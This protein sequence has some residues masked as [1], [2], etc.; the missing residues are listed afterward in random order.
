VDE[1]VAPDPGVWDKILKERQAAAAAEALAKAE[2][3]GRGR[4]AKAVCS[5]VLSIRTNINITQTVDYATEEKGADAASVA[6]DD[7][8]ED[9]ALPPSPIKKLSR[10]RKNKTGSESDT[11]FQADS[12]DESEPEPALDDVDAS[13][14]LGDTRHR[15]TTNIANSSL[16]KQN[17]AG[18]SNVSS[19]KFS[20]VAIAVQTTPKKDGVRVVRTPPKPLQ[21]V[22]PPRGGTRVR[23][24]LVQTPRN[25]SLEQC[26]PQRAPPAFIDLST[27]PPELALQGTRTNEAT[28]KP[29]ERAT[30]PIRNPLEPTYGSFGNRICPACHKNHPQ[31][32]C[33]LKVAGVE[34]CGLCGLAHFG[35]SRTCPHIKSETQVREMLEA[36]KNSPEKKELV[37]AAMKYLRGVKGTLVQQKKR[38]RE[39]AAL[40]AGQPIPPPTQTGTSRPPKSAY[41]RPPGATNGTTNGSSP[42][43]SGPPGA[44]SNEPPRSYAPY[45]PQGQG[46]METVQGSVGSIP[47]GQQRTFAQQQQMVQQ[48]QGQGFDD[49]QVESALRGF[50][51]QS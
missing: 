30:I 20:A 19:S 26:P 43:P 12:E 24:D 41:P 8:F 42:G 14:E 31:G 15:N 35:H 23:L 44:P 48:M 49:Q 2:A 32:A 38:D 18:A 40:A 4:R 9:S 39:K 51:F 16:Y 3:M 50:L 25:A 34:H 11:D 46:R 29:F 47:P 22:V 27:P 21:G 6:G 28:V 7:H 13:K 5:S 45:L 1:E 10:K 33:E 17:G 37:D 36:L